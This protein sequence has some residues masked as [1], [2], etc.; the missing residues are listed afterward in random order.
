MGKARYGRRQ[1][2]PH[3]EAN[4]LARFRSADPGRPS[5]HRRL[6]TAATRTLGMIVSPAGLS[7]AT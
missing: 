3:H 7:R 1:R 6:K 5:G 4:K 2:L